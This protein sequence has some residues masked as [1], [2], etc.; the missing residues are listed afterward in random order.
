MRFINKIIELIKQG[1]V[2][3]QYSHEN[4]VQKSDNLRA[5]KVDCSGFVEFW[6]SRCHPRALK[7]LYSFVLKVRDTKKYQITRLYSVDFYD[8]FAYLKTNSSPN[9]ERVDYRQSFQE[10]DILAFINP[11]KQ[12]RCAHVGIIKEEISR[13]SSKIMVRIADSSKISHYNDWR[14]SENMGIGE[15]EITLIINNGIIDNVLYNNDCSKYRLVEIGRLKKLI[16]KK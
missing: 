14:Q 2:R 13:D 3:T 4:E 16:T 9:W 7:E 15:G 5:I 12:S 8:Y 11:E 6:L 1:K 10:G